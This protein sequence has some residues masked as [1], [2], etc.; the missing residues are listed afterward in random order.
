MYRAVKSLPV[1]GKY[2]HGALLELIN[3]VDYKGK[4]LM[5]EASA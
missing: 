4:N 5:I 3:T 1:M 2:T